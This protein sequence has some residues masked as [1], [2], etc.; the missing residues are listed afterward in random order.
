MEGPILKISEIPVPE[1]YKESADFRFFLNWFEHALTEIRYDTENIL[2]L[3]DPLRCKSELLWM[4]ADTMGFKF[5]DRL[6]VAFNRLVLLY[7]MSM[8]RNK[9]SKNGMMLAAEVN[10]AQFNINEYGKSNN[11]LY[12]RL[13]DAS[14]PVNAVYVTPHVKEGYIDVV[15]FSS[16]KPVDACIEYVRPLGMYC[17][18]HAGVRVDSR[19]KI[20]VDARLTNMDEMHVTSHP[21]RIGHYRRSDYASMQRESSCENSR[22]VFTYNGN[23]YY[24]I[25]DVH[26]ALISSNS[27][28]EFDNSTILRMC[29][30]TATEVFEKYPELKGSMSVSLNKNQVDTTHKRNRVY[31]NNKDFEK[32]PTD[33]INPGYRTLYSLQLCN[34]EHIVKSMIPEKESEHGEMTESQIFGLGYGPLDVTTHNEDKVDAPEMMF[35]LIY[36][37]QRDE[38]YT[39]SKDGVYDVST[40]D[41]G[42]RDPSTTPAVN[43]PMASLGDAI[44]LP[45][46]TYSNA[47]NGQIGIVDVQGDASTTEEQ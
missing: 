29:Q 4:L 9:G 7:F 35:N 13:E 41:D 33:H 43:P 47:E 12:D 2:D 37:K 18:Q 11:V 32:V 6:P 36:H 27:E 22:Y 23:T 20:S 5:D 45:D 14:I 30:G 31:R 39:Y 17:F 42:S 38:Q 10:L 16:Q 1:V 19:T 44:Q 46:R 21:T 8:I 26:E 34:N 3:Y 15:Y 28:Y 25:S 24:R 40:S